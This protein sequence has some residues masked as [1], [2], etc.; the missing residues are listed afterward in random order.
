[1]CFGRMP[2]TCED[3]LRSIFRFQCVTQGSEKH[4]NLSGRMSERSLDVLRTSLLAGEQRERRGSLSSLHSEGHYTGVS[5]GNPELPRI[6][7]SVEMNAFHSGDRSP[8]YTNSVERQAVGWEKH[9][10]DQ[11][12]T[13]YW[14]K[15]TNESRWTPP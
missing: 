6:S 12:R 1:M 10:D 3:R 14:N 8:E 5:A 13:Y 9:K 7:H 4:K 11:G 2:A 15:E